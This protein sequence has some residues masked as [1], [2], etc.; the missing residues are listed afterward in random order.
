MPCSP[1]TPCSFVLRQEEE[2]ADTENPMLVPGMYTTVML[3]G[4]SRPTTFPS[5]NQHIHEPSYNPDNAWVLRPLWAHNKKHLSQYYLCPLSR[6]TEHG[7]IRPWSEWWPWD[8]LLPSYCIHCVSYCMA[9]NIVPITNYHT[10][11]WSWRYVTCWCIHIILT[12][13]SILSNNKINAVYTPQGYTVTLN[14][15]LQTKI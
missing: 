12:K 13:L 8:V 1:T 6:H 11:H 2:T 7:P 15:S 5:Q 10:L 9:L 14:K 4:E 3:H